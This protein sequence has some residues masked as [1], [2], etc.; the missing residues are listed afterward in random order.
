MEGLTKASV[1]LELIIQGPDTALFKDLVQPNEGPSSGTSDSNAVNLVVGFGLTAYRPIQSATAAGPSYEPFGKHAVAERDED[2]PYHGPG[3]RI[4][5]DYDND[6]AYADGDDDFGE[7]PPDGRDLDLAGPI[8]NENDLIEIHIQTPPG[9]GPAVL[10]QNGPDL[11]VYSSHDKTGELDFDGFESEPIDASGGVTYFVEW[12]TINEGITVLQLWNDDLTLKLDSLTFHSFD[13]VVIGLS[14]RT[15]ED[16]TFKVDTFK[17]VALPLY[18][19]GFDVFFTNEENVKAGLVDYGKGAVLT[20]IK[21]SLLRHVSNVAAFGHSQGGGSIYN[22][23]RRLEKD[24]IEIN[25]AFT[26]Y[27]DAVK[28]GKITAEDR[29]PIDTDLHSNYFQTFS[30]PLQGVKLTDPGQYLR[31]DDVNVDLG[32][33]DEFGNE[34]NHQTIDNSDQ[35]HAELLEDFDNEFKNKRRR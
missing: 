15:S 25:L 22:L 31:N 24:E 17:G 4:N 3:I 6:P 11:K 35:L 33:R 20:G 27:I 28:D 1:Q 8:P 32:W 13:T 2:D 34:F 16:N 10:V 21:A 7:M 30:L 14:G 12:A 18:K 23:S 9:F 26:V 29:R 5:S 19:Q